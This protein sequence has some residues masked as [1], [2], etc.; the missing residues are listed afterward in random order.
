MLK[1]TLKPGDY[2][3]IGENIRVVFSGGSANN[4][5]LLVDA[6]REM[7]IA[8]SSAERKSNRTHY[9]KEQG[10]SEQAQKEIAAIIT[11]VAFYAGW[12]K[13]WAV[14]NLAKEVWDVN[15]GNLPYEDEAMR[16]HAKEMV[17]PIG[18]PNDGFAQYFSGK[19][20]LAPVSK[21]QVGIFNVTFEP[22]CRNNWH[23]H[24][25]KNGGGQILVCVAGRGY[26]QEEGKEAIEMKTGDCINIPAEVKHWH[27]AAPDSW[28]SHLAV[29]VPG[30]ETSNEWCEPVS[31]EEYA[32]LK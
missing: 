32:K 15:G 13:G 7:N 9:Y 19:S 31:D 22:G 20:F 30:E 14:F 12:P 6:P 21:S 17:F 3:D 2:I 10:I 24:H 11:H 27:G 29:E 18:A 23:I 4:I 8:R 25:A 26:Y 5:H 16:A 28:F 1:L